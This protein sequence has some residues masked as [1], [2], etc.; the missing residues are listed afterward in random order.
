MIIRAPRLLNR[1]SCAT[2]R[3]AP[4]SPGYEPAARRGSV[5]DDPTLRRRASGNTR[6]MPDF[7][8]QPALASG[9]TWL[10]IEVSAASTMDGAAAQARHKRQ[11]DYLAWAY[12]AP[13]FGVLE[14]HKVYFR[15]FSGG[16]TGEI[17]RWNCEEPDTVPVNAFCH[18]IDRNADGAIIPVF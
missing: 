14:A 10:T 13:L 6:A 18:S 2:A 1:I 4:A 12:P 9:M 17:Y 8:D 15:P 11:V 16:S 3:P 5:C 7:F